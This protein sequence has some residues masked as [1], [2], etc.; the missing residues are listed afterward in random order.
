M[1]GLSP[2]PPRLPAISGTGDY[3]YGL[4]LYHTPFLQ[5]LIHYFP[6]ALTGDLWWMLFFAGFALSLT[7]AVI[8][9]H[10]LEYPVLKL[11]NS[12]VIRHRPESGLGFGDRHAANSQSAARIPP[13]SG[14]ARDARSE[15]DDVASC[16]KDSRR[17]PSPGR[18]VAPQ[19]SPSPSPRARSPAGRA[20]GGL[21][22]CA[23]SSPIRRSASA[24]MLSGAWIT[25]RSSAQR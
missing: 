6:E 11:R 25:S 4:Y 18:R 15:V 5:L 22:V 12:F 3:S 23:A 2:M 1:I 10:V 17:E 21:A 16:P 19:F 14:Q 13:I 7:A 24:A 8:S 9:W 20:I